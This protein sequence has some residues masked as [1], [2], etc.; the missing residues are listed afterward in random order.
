[1]LCIYFVWKKILFRAW[2]LFKAVGVQGTTGNIPPTS[3]TG[4]GQDAWVPW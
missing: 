1:M 4:R 2:I 3:L